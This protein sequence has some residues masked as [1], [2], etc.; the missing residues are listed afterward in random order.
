MRLKVLVVLRVSKMLQQGDPETETLTLGSLQGGGS[1]SVLH[2]QLSIP[3]HDLE[4]IA[5]QLIVPGDIASHAVLENTITLNLIGIVALVRDQIEDQDLCTSDHSE[6]D[7]HVVGLSS[8]TTS[9]SERVGLTRWGIKTL[10][11]VGA[12]L[13]ANGSS[14]A[15][16]LISPDLS[17]AAATFRAV[18]AEGSTTCIKDTKSKGTVEDLDCFEITL[19]TH[20]RDMHHWGLGSDLLGSEA[21]IT[22]V[23]DII[24]RVRLRASEGEIDIGS[25][26]WSD[27]DDPLR[28]LDRDLGL[29]GPT[30]L[31]DHLVLV[32]RL[33]SRGRDHV[34]LVLKSGLTVVG[35]GELLVRVQEH[36]VVQGDAGGADLSLVRE[37]VHEVEEAGALLGHG[38]VAFESLLLLA[39][40][41][42]VLEG[43]LDGVC[44]VISIGESLEVEG[45]TSDN[46]GC[47]H[48]RA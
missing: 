17:M 23:D 37:D 46:I 24:R 18:G 48:G 8:G 29:H 30:G 32:K 19:H 14:L 26:T 39:G 13:V 2:E 31:V 12:D 36:G 43:G 33:E 21:D 44:R 6:D 10:S 15:H 1:C 42:R 3:A 38:S 5:L 4:G 25:R 47:R 45:N 34:N 35:D 20:V 40:L 16:N 11:W 28:I 9:S 41:T 22:R 7:L 27:L